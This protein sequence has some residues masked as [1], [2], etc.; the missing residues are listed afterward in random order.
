MRSIALASV[1]AHGGARIGAHALLV[2]D[3]RRREPFENVDLGR[4][5]RRHEAL[6]KAL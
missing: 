5:E 6:H 3:D 2:D 1:G 4:A